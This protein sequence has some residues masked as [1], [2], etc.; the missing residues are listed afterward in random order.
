MLDRTPFLLATLL[1]GVFFEFPLNLA[2]A[3]DPE[4]SRA[5]LTRPYRS[6]RDA[7]YRRVDGEKLAA[8]IFR[9]ANDE[10][11]P[12]VLMIHGG[13][14]SSGDKWHLHDHARELAQEGYVAISI[15]YRLA[16]LHQITEQI[17]DC[18]VALE[19]LGNSAEKYKIDPKRIAIWGYSAGA[20]L[21][22]ML[23]T[24]P[25]VN[26]P[27]IIAVVVGGAPCDFLNI[28]ENSQVLSLVM[29]GSRKELPK[30][31]HDMSP[32]NF[33]NTQCPPT[34]FFHGSAD[35]IVAPATSRRMFEALKSNGV[36]TEYV[37]IE[38]KGHLTTFLDST[39]RR[40]AIEFLNKHLPS[41]H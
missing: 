4:L 11:C 1:V 18:R 14:W 28:P 8:D 13:A 15:N 33:V 6:V 39:A 37:T 9:P 34:L 27:P 22:C 20:H 23:S 7:V 41:D 25:A 10:V 36:E 29:G 32:L 31:Y 17:D 26:S 35:L 21:A 30:L 38:G 40:K 16:P 2:L 3:E 19:W 24:Q 5:A 12:A